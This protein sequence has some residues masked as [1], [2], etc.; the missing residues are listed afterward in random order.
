[1]ISCFQ[2]VVDEYPKGEDNLPRLDVAVIQEF[3]RTQIPDDDPVVI[4]AG[5]AAK[6][7]GTIPENQDFRR[8]I[9]C[10]CLF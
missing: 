10:Q 4:L 7:L 8:R 2:K 1:M 5:K 9:G 6:K 3:P